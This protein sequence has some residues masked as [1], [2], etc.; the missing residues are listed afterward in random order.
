M[1]EIYCAGAI[2][3]DTR[4]REYYNEII[5]TVNAAGYTALSEL[6]INLI[7]KKNL[8]DNEIYERDIEWLAESTKMIAEISGPSLGVGFEIA[9]ALYVLKIPVLALHH[10]SADKISAMITGCSSP[11]LKTKSYKDSEQLKE[12]VISFLKE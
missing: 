12:E 4:Y 3:G 5:H 7:I 8:S 6:N 1:K 11:L 9:Y 10:S 2:K